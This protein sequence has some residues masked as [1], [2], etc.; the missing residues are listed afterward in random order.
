MTKKS[1][2]KTKK[3]NQKTKKSNQKT[4]KSNQKIKLNKKSKS[5]QKTKSNK[6]SKSKDRKVVERVK[7]NRNTP[8]FRMNG[9][10]DDEKKQGGLD[11]P[12]IDPTIKN[13]AGFLDEETYYQLRLT[14]RAY[15]T[16]LKPG[17]KYSQLIELL[18][19]ED[20]FNT[21]EKVMIDSED[22]FVEHKGKLPTRLRHLKLGRGFNKPLCDFGKN[23]G[24]LFPNLTCLELGN[25][26]NQNLGKLPESLR[27]LTCG[28]NF[29]QPLGLLPNLEE[30]ILG[31]MFNQNLGKLPKSLTYIYGYKLYKK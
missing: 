3:S 21:Y 5:N 26:F 10:G 20:K 4:K 28:Y 2:Q 12:G 13:T 1:N 19:N 14:N 22:S 7:K 27:V 18:P 31:K 11:Q 8:R 24:D 16:K 6:K 29:N 9:S 30:L 15:S 23:L 25:S 17:I